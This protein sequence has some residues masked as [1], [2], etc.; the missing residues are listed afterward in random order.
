MT[1]VSDPQALLKQTHGY[2]R[3]RYI[4]ILSD[5]CERVLRKI[6]E[7]YSPKRVLEIGTAIGY[8]SSVMALISD[9]V[10]DTVEKDGERIAAAKEL[11]TKLGVSERINAYHGDA[12]GT[13]ADIVEGK[14]YDFVFLDGAK[15]AYRRQLEFLEPHIEK[16]GIVLCDDVLYLG[17]VKGDGV[18]PHKH[19]TIV[20]NMRAFLNYLSQSGKYDSRVIDEAN[21]IAVA[22][23]K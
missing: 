16:G 20:N 21:G 19:R 15:S 12:D 11:W 2:A 14:T 23:K 13:L 18:P 10:I 17:L 22:R 3:E 9:C 1:L 7:T 6:F 5:E 8:S 4:M